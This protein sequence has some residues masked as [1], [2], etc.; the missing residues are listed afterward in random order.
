MTGYEPDDYYDERG[1]DERR[2]GRDEVY[3]T[4]EGPDRTYRN[5]RIANAV[6]RLMC[7]FFALVLVAHVVL[8]LVNANEENWLA[9]IVKSI[10]N[11]VSFGLTDLFTFDSVRVNWALGNAVA[12]VIWLVIGAGVSAVIRSALM[13]THSRVVRRRR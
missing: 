4:V 11:G 12:V 6:V 8:V 5:L 2:R 3:E 1:Y 10:A 9:S 13:P 7:A